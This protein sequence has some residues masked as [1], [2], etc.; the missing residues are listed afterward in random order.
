MLSR[1]CYKHPFSQWHQS[2]SFRAFAKSSTNGAAK[3]PPIRHTRVQQGNDGKRAP[4]LRLVPIELGNPHA[5][6]GNPAAKGF[7]V[8]M[9]SSTWAHL[10]KLP[11]S[12]KQILSYVYFNSRQGHGA[13]TCHIWGARSTSRVFR[14][15]PRQTRHSQSAGQS[16]PQEASDTSNSEFSTVSFPTRIW[17]STLSFSGYTCVPDTSFTATGPDLTNLH[18]EVLLRKKRKRSSKAPNDMFQDTRTGEWI[19][20]GAMQDDANMGSQ[21]LKKKGTKSAFLIFTYYKND[22]SW[23]YVFHMH[24]QH[25][26]VDS[27]I[28]NNRRFGSAK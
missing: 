18:V 19:W 27:C 11:K 21:T 16:L 23:F 15:P 1:P 8:P 22:S 20:T 6:R 2:S 14:T 17:S 13:S 3:S 24:L 9:S 28:F 25:S 7:P 10:T 4:D 26:I 5:A 12:F